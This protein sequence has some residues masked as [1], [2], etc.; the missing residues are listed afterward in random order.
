ML[1]HKSSLELFV[2]LCLFEFWSKKENRRNLFKKKKKEKGQAPWA[3]SPLSLRAR[4]GLCGPAAAQL[5]RSAP[6]PAPCRRQVGPTCQWGGR[7]QPPVRNRRGSR[8]ASS[9]VSAPARETRFARAF[10]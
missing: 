4:V 1:L 2:Y 3:G 8:A 10:K 9:S 5:Q 6:A 7:P